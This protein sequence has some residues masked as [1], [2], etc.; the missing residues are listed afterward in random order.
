MT[1]ELQHHGYGSLEIPTVSSETE[2]VR[3]E[4]KEGSALKQ[5]SDE[6]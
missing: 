2:E 4:S 6:E 1:P 3:P 5:A